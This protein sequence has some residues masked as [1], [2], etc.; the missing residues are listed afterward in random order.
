VV[1]R[2]LQNAWSRAG[3]TESIHNIRPKQRFWG[4]ST[5]MYQSCQHLITLDCECEFMSTG[6]CATV[7]N[8]S[9][10]LRAVAVAVAALQTGPAGPLCTQQH[11]ISDCNGHKGLE[12]CRLCSLSTLLP[13]KH[14]CCALKSM[15][16]WV[17]LYSYRQLQLLLDRT[18]A[19]SQAWSSSHWPHPHDPVLLAEGHNTVIQVD[20][21]VA[22]AWLQQHLG[23]K[24]WQLHRGMPVA[25]GPQQVAMLV[26]CTHQHQGQGGYMQQWAMSKD[27]CPRVVCCTS[28]EPGRWSARPQ[29][30]RKIQG[31]RCKNGSI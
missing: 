22:V 10:C 14:M 31:S 23:A 17:L 28:S 29:G 13:L 5:Y 3:S 27:K 19:K 25:L 26:T 18:Q 11:A 2:C 12:Q 9:S 6:S 21:G 20:C 15:A 1:L 8:P 16:C 30:V 24:G 4:R 7:L